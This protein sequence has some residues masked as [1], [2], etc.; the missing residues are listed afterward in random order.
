MPYHDRVTVSKLFQI[1]A[2]RGRRAAQSIFDGRSHCPDTVRPKIPATKC[3]NRRL[4][5]YQVS[6]ALDYLHGL[7]IAIR[8]NVNLEK[9]RSLEMIFIALSGYAGFGA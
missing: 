8:M 3:C 2:R 5:Q 6:Y 4:I 9:P 1:T 7:H